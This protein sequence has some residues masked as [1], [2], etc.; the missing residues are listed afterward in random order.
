MKMYLFMKMY[1]TNHLVSQE[2]NRC[3]SACQEWSNRRTS[4]AKDEARTKLFLND[5]VPVNETAGLP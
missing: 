2:N 1:L 3:L 4:I 5:D